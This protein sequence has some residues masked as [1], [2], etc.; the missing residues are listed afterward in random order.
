MDFAD[1]VLR[2]AHV[3]NIHGVI[4]ADDLSITRVALDFPLEIVAEMSLSADI[5]SANVRH[6]F[7]NPHSLFSSSLK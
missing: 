5:S 4:D 3:L 2:I 1:R 7:A 6:A